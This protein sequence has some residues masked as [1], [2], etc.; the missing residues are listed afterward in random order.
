MNSQ[1]ENTNSKGHFVLKN[2]LNVRFKDFW[3]TKRNLTQIWCI[4]LK[5]IECYLSLQ[6]LS[7]YNT[8]FQPQIIINC[9]RQTKSELK[10]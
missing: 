1:H 9:I 5:G 10:I 7:T 2:D 4:Q 6:I 3:Y 8:N